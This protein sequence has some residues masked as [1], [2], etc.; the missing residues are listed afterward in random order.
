M[1]FSLRSGGGVRRFNQQLSESN[2]EY[3][4]TREQA[5]NKLKETGT[6]STGMLQP[7]GIPF[8]VFLRSVHLSKRRHAL[9]IE[10]L[11]AHFEQ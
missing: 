7:L 3:K 9:F 5:L 11:I 10:K 8:E 2:K 6:L 1:P 4:V